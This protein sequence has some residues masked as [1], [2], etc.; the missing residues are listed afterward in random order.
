MQPIY[1]IETFVYKFRTD[2]SEHAN[3]ACKTNLWIVSRVLP[4]NTLHESND[5]E[6]NYTG[7][8]VE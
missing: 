8:V 4:L 1:Y 5:Q 7:L 2:L 3:L 6:H